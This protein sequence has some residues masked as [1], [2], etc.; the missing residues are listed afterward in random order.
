MLMQESRQHT[1]GHV[2][3]HYNGALLHAASSIDTTPGVMRSRKSP[4]MGCTERRALY[5]RL[6][7]YITGSRAAPRW[8]FSHMPVGHFL[9]KVAMVERTRRCDCAK[10]GTN[11]VSNF[12]ADTE[13]AVADDWLDIITNA[14][15]GGDGYRRPI[16]AAVLPRRSE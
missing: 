15:A 3:V 4:P 12:A 7:Q 6:R 16:R 10:A 2:A 11:T 9:A 8:H 14:Y 1:R 13:E 5:R